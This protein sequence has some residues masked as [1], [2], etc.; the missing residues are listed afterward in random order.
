MGFSRV[1][2]WGATAFSRIKEQEAINV[3]NKGPNFPG[4]LCE[5]NAIDICHWASPYCLY[6]FY[7]LLFHV[8]VTTLLCSMVGPSHKVSSTLLKV[9]AINLMGCLLLWISLTNRSKQ[10]RSCFILSL[11]PC[12][13]FQVPQRHLCSWPSSIL[14]LIL[15]SFIFSLSLWPG[16]IFFLRVLTSQ[17]QKG[18]TRRR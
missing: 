13:C 8:G 1:L 10:V 6:R 15:S 2:E 7:C 14:L 3:N 9:G 18:W 16:Q 17:G 11:H 12:S 4:E 5:G